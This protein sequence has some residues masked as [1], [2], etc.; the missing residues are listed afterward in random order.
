MTN[1]SC[2]TTLP[3]IH[4]GAIPGE[5]C[6][7]HGIIDGFKQMDGPI[8][9]VKV[10]RTTG[11]NVPIAYFLSPV[12]QTREASNTPVTMKKRR[13]KRL[14]YDPQIRLSFTK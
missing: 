11:R 12:G 3:L 2:L 7:R 8:K 9:S 13:I 1:R 4:D 10:I 5:V 14:R 6:Q